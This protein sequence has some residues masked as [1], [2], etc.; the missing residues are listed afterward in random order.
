ID[1]Q[2]VDIVRELK[3]KG[4]TTF[5][6]LEIPLV[7]GKEVKIFYARYGENDSL[8]IDRINGFM[9]GRVMGFTWDG[10]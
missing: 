8:H 1:G 7:A 3:S 6:D 5:L 4:L 10:N 2:R 9:E